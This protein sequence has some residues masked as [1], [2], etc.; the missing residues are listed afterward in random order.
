MEQ[1]D[2]FQKMVG[3]PVMGFVQ[4]NW[5]LLLIVALLGAA[6]FFGVG[7]TNDSGTG[8]TLFA[9]GSSDDGDSGGDGG[10]GDGGGGG[11]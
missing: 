6:W 3:A 7:R 9:D 2:E 1:I 5:W 11:D 4:Q 8:V 10:G